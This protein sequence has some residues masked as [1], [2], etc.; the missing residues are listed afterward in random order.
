MI[1]GITLVGGVLFFIL[2]VWREKRNKRANEA[3]EPNP[4]SVEMKRKYGKPSKSGLGRL[5]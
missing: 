3:P 4:N 2:I 1:L 5:V